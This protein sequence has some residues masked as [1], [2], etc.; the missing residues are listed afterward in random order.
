MFRYGAF[1]LA[2]AAA[3]LITAC[4]GD[5]PPE[6]HTPVPSPTQTTERLEEIPS[7]AEMESG[8][9]TLAEAVFVQLANEHLTT[10]ISED[11]LVAAA[12]A[13]C[14]AMDRGDSLQSVLIII[15]GLLPELTTTD[16]VANIG[17]AAS[18]TIC[19]EHTDYVS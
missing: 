5:T 14:D 11:R 13:A 2:I 8:E 18:G 7:R 16:Q 1:A 17:G 9:R 15:A 3:L 6:S 4:T 10:G 19:P 12:D